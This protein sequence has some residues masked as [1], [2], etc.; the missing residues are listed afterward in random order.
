MMVSPA[1]LETLRKMFVDDD[2]R[3]RV[4][5]TES[6]CPVGHPKAIS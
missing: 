3:F 4:G 6:G 1:K 5:H 2:H